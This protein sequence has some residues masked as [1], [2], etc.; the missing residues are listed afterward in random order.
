MKEKTEKTLIVNKK[1]NLTAV[2]LLGV[3]AS[4]VS[5]KTPKRADLVPLQAPMIIGKYPVSI[6]RTI[7]S[8]SYK[9]TVISSV[10]WYY[11]KNAAGK[12]SLELAQATHIEL[13]LTDE[14][15]LNAT[16]FKGNV[17]LKTEVVK[18]NLRKGYFRTKH[19][20]SLKGVPPFYWSMSSAKMQFGIGKERQLYIDSADETNG[21]ILIMVAGT[22][23]FTRS[24]TVPVYEK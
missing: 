15:H 19:D 21:S 5:L 7:K 14:N 8:R 3:F 9:D 1:V 17:P 22:P 12:D 23:G 13:K 11:F 24:L 4:C 2:V 10:L 16:L 18:G 20:L 6:N